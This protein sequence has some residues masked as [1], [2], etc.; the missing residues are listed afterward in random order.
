MT[1]EHINARMDAIG[2]IERKRALTVPE[3]AELENLAY[4]RCQQLRRAHDQIERAE[5]KLRRLR[6]IVGCRVAA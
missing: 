5:A 2:A 6:A 4:N 1:F 3:Q